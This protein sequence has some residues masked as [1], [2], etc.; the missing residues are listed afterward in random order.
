MRIH[1]Y[2]SDEKKKSK[3]CMRTYVRVCELL[4][5]KSFCLNRPIISQ[6]MYE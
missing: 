2:T 4:T 1:A 6:K 3:M 5:H